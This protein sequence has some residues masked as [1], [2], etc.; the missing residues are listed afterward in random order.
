[1]RK[2][3]LRGSVLSST[4]GFMQKGFT[5]LQESQDFFQSPALIAFSLHSLIHAPP[6]FSTIPRLCPETTTAR[7]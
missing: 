4:S 1:M 7:Q 5:G 6:V 2:G 3:V